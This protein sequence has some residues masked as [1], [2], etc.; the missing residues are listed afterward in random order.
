MSRHGFECGG[1]EG[2]GVGDEGGSEARGCASGG[3]GA[4]CHVRVRVWRGWLAVIEEVVGAAR[5]RS[6]VGRAGGGEAVGQRKSRRGKEEDGR[7][8]GRL[9]GEDERSQQGGGRADEGKVGWRG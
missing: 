6:A 9:G 3:G 7:T 1:K 2:G 8:R 4:L 5:R